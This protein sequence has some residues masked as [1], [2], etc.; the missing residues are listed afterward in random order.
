M[1][2][3]EGS[4][5]LR[6]LGP[7][8]ERQGVGSGR[9]PPPGEQHRVL[10]APPEARLVLPDAGPVEGLTPVDEHADV[11]RLAALLAERAEQRDAGGVDDERRRHRRDLV[12]DRGRP[13]PGL[14]RVDHPPRRQGRGGD[15]ERE[16]AVRLPRRH[17][18]RRRRPVEEAAE[19]AVRGACR[20]RGGG[21]PEDP[22]ARERL[23]AEG[24]HVHS[25]DERL[26]D[27]VLGLQVGEHAEAVAQT[28]VHPSRRGH[29]LVEVRP[30]SGVPEELDPVPDHVAVDRGEEPMWERRTGAPVVEQV[31]GVERDARVEEGRPDGAVVGAGGGEVR[32]FPRRPV[33]E[34]RRLDQVRVRLERLE[35]VRAAAGLL[36][37]DARAGAKGVGA[38]TLDERECRLRAGERDPIARRRV[39]VEQRDRVPGRHVAPGPARAATGTGLCVRRR[40]PGQRS[41]G[42]Q[43]ARVVPG[44]KPQGERVGEGVGAPVP[45]QGRAARRVAHPPEPAARVPPAEQRPLCLAT[46]LGEGLRAIGTGQGRRRQRQHRRR[47]G[48]EPHA[49]HASG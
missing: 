14:G 34:Q 42:C 24:Q 1:Q 19:R 11:T 16:A 43:E 32:G 30:G 44:A 12:A 35:A 26:D 13:G 39:L 20:E 28:S 40:C 21:V 37:V 41:E 7:G 23:A 47:A 33:Q 46:R 9:P 48:E 22:R 38:G 3:E 29:G 5:L 27:V 8:L 15:L 36:V 17:G 10:D 25:L 49:A 31:H 4:P 6:V 2:V 45:V 18:G